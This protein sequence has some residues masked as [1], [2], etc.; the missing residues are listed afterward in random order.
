MLHSV[1]TLSKQDLHDSLLLHR[2]ANE[3][4]VFVLLSQHLKTE[5]QSKTKPD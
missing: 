4:L 3:A 5:G 2:E 1:T